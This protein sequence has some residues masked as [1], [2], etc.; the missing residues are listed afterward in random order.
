MKIVFPTLLLIFTSNILLSQESNTDNTTPITPIPDFH[1][2]GFYLSGGFM[3]HNIG[4][5]TNSVADTPT[6][7]GL[8]KTYFFQ[9]QV[10][11]KHNLAINAAYSFTPDF[12]GNNGETI[13]SNIYGLNGH[14]PCYRSFKHKGIF[15]ESGFSAELIRIVNH[16]TSTASSIQ[17]HVNM[18]NALGYEYKF[19][20]VQLYIMSR[21]NIMLNNRPDQKKEPYI[22]FYGSVDHVIGIRIML[23]SLYKKLN[24]RYHWL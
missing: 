13:Q 4:I 11:F 18:L 8:Q 16:S 24:D 9:G 7:Y 2:N 3:L 22:P 23:P 17:T 6:F 10:E 20:R 5:Y 15:I 19:K 21:L 12:I 14:F 1:T